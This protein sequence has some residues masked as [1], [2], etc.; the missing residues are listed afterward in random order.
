MACRADQQV[1]P[2]M[3]APSFHRGRG[4][5]QYLHAESSCG[6]S[7]RPSP[8]EEGVRRLPARCLGT[9]HGDPRVRRPTR[10]AAFLECRGGELV[11]SAGCEPRE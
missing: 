3:T 4:R 2:V 11:V 8:F 9:Q 7:A 10:G 5:A 1:R 6:I